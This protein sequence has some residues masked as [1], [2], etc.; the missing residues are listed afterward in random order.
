[1]P[2]VNNL[3]DR[4]DKMALFSLKEAFKITSF[5]C[6]LSRRKTL[7]VGIVDLFIGGI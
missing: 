7:G 3:T 1:M 2:S 5:Y 4:R 6:K